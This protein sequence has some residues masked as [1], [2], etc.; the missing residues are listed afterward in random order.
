[1][2]YLFTAQYNDGTEFKQTDEDVSTKDPLRSAFF[3][4]EHDKLTAF[5]LH[6]ADTSVRVNLITG[7]FTVNSSSFFAHDEEVINRRL[8]YFRRNV[9]EFNADRTEISHTIAFHVG[10]QGNDPK[11][12]ENVQRVLVFN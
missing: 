2:K 5:Q 4:L 7:E 11:T 3:D 1:M 8:V 12:G 10:W 6:S 9:R